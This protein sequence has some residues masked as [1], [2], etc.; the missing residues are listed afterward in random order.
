[1][2][3]YRRGYQRYQGD[4]TGRWTRF[5]VL[6]RYSWEKLLQQRLVVIVLVVA[7]FWPLGC[8]GFIYVANHKDLLLSLIHI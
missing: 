2:A 7:L 3:V 5:L 1:M 8:A 6:P 4:L